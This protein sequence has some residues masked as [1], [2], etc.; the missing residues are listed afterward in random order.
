V[1]VITGAAVIVDLLTRT[2]GGTRS[3][4]DTEGRPLRAV[5]AVTAAA[6][7][8]IGIALA[9][10]VNRNNEVAVMMGQAGPDGD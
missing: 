2:I 4:A 6:A 3:S 8:R 5:S 1:A 10:N 9:R 7:G